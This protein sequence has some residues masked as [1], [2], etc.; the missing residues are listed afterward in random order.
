MNTHFESEI[1]SLNSQGQGI[2]SVNGLKVFVDYALSSEKIKG[3]I[4][5]QKKSFARGAL[6]EIVT[7]SSDRIPAICP[8]FQK[9]GGCQIMHLSYA[10][11]VEF[12]QQKVSEALEKIAHIKFPVSPCVASSSPFEYRNKIQLPFF[13]QNGKIKLGLYQK[14]SHTPLAIDRCYIHCE[15]GEKVFCAFSKL[16]ENSPLSVFDEKTRTGLLR[17]LLI[18]TAIHTRQCL[19]TIITSSKKQLL[20][21][22]DL[23]LELM[24]QCPEVQGVVLNINKKRINSIMGDL[25][26]PLVGQPY[27]HEKLCGKTFKISAH[28]FF[29][30]HIGQAEKLY[31]EALKQAHIQGGDVVLDAYC[32][33]GTLAL[34]ASG[35]CKEVVGIESVK[36]AIDDARA[37]AKLNQITN[38]K[39]VLGKVEDSID[40]IPKINIALINPPRRGCEKKVLEALY[41][42][43][44][45]KIV[46]IS[47]D[48]ATL[49]RDLTYLHQLGYETHKVQ[50]FD[51]FPQTSHVETCVTL[52]LK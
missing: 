50:P 38:C 52:E 21:L 23:A 46:Y 13:K 28:S 11:Q 16:I 44:P 33:T 42:L 49:A 5:E 12:K 6:L 22:K 20:Q 36:S 30:V 18:K 29:Q 37:N 7:P 51:M 39:F 31:L 26:L 45:R 48:P 32:G 2:C 19:V 24:R 43:R 47:C 41:K 14:N 9:C 10:K 8:L 27:I 17:H 1:T 25:W 4:V 40:Q 3:E 34:L 35:H 15:L